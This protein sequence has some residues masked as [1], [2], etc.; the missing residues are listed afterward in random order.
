VR[1]LPLRE[2][3]RRLHAAGFKVRL[4]NASSG[5]TAPSAGTVAPPGTVVQLNR[6][7]E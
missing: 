3:V 2:A 1:G 5:G 4:S 7:I 6:P